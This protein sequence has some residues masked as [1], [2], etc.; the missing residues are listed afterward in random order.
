MKRRYILIVD[1][2]TNCNIDIYE[3]K[4]L[5]TV[6]KKINRVFGVIYNEFEDISHD[7]S[8]TLVQSFLINFFILIGVLNTDKNDFLNEMS[9]YY[10]MAKQAEVDGKIDIT[11]EV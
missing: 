8:S 11:N 1:K 7:Y 3:K 4:K 9:N 2:N 6:T 5:K 10:D